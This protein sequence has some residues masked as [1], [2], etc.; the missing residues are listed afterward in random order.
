ML[1]FFETGELKTIQ[2]IGVMPVYNST[3]RLVV[4]YINYT[5]HY[6]VPLQHSPTHYI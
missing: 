3:E 1:P 5:K 4:S 6:K 2:L